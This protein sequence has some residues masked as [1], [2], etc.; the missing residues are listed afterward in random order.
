VKYT[1]T[2]LE[3]LDINSF[4]DLLNLFAQSF[5]LSK[6]KLKKIFSLV[7]NSIPYRSVTLIKF[8]KS[9]VGALI[10]VSRKIWFKNINLSV[11]GM[12]FMAK[13]KNYNDIKIS[14]LLIK[15]VLNESE[16]KDV[17]IGFASK[18][19]DYYWYRY[20]FVGVT[21]FSELHFDID[22]YFL[23]KD[24]KDYSFENVEKDDLIKLNY[25]YE[26]TYRSISCSFLRDNLLWRYHFKKHSDTLNFIKITQ[27]SKI[28]GYF[29]HKEN[30][31]YEF[32]FL[33]KIDR[34]AVQILKNYFNT[35]DKNEIIFYLSFK[36]PLL[37][38]LKNFSHK[39]YE[40][41]VH[42]GGHVIR[43]N[44]IKNFLN[45]I[46]PEI[47]KSLNEQNIFKYYKKTDG[48]LFDYSNKKLNISYDNSFQDTN[49]SKRNITKFIFGLKKDEEID[50]IISP[51]LSINFSIID[52]F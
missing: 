19:M 9:I 24:N 3:S 29:V 49:T 11:C 51:D 21:N 35:L 39:K 7:L 40:K 6:T 25:I 43:I 47:E 52:Q 22:K 50:N 42:E 10:L 32:A 46:K 13:N 36:H 26:K 8:E 16:L 31:I 30:K 33:H 38:F 44:N 37:L 20:G 4:N 15:T 45:K 34:V 48:V 18:K 17:S 28:I 5:S 2:Q 23:K 14:N 1:K 41:Y 12:S 27:N